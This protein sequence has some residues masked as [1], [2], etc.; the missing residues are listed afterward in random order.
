MI[1]DIIFTISALS[2]VIGAL[3]AIRFP[4]FYTRTHALTMVTVGGSVLGLLAF[5]ATGGFGVYSVKTLLAAAFIMITS[6]V[7][8]HAIAQAAHA[9]G[10]K[11]IASKDA[12]SEK[13]KA[14]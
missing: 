1:E 11:P 10:L 13:K 8:A 12:L 2:A 5:A 14:D 4:D 3:G 6:P 9:S 7:S